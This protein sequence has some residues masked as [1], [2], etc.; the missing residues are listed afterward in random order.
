MMNNSDFI[1][2]TTEELGHHYRE[3][4]NVDI[5]KFLVVPN[6]IPKWWF[7][8]FYDLD[9]INLRYDSLKNRKPRIGFPV[10]ASHY[11]Q[12][13]KNGGIDDFTHIVDLVKETIDKYQWVFVC[14]IPAQLNTDECRDKLEVYSGWD[15][16]NYPKIILSQILNFF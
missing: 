14:G 2:V 8:G 10:S 3:K 5:T 6:Y 16:Y 13:N 1:T 4:Y 12:D 7:D 9:K 15:I 11:D